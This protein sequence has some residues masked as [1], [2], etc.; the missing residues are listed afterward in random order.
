M[1]AIWK[2]PLEVT[3]VQVLAVPGPGIPLTVQAQNGQPCLWF[4]V[5]RAKKVEDLEVLTFGTGH[6][7]PT[8]LDASGAV[9]V[10]TYQKNGGA[11]VF[12]VFVRAI[13]GTS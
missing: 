7:L 5:D 2:Y 13:G 3:D 11:L 4:R 9:Y 10:G 6:R 12:H 8:D 1:E